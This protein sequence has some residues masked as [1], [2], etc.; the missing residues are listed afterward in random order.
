MI[1]ILGQILF[2]TMAAAFALLVVTLA[3]VGLSTVRD[4]E[5]LYS[6]GERLF[7]GVFGVVLCIFCATGTTILTYLA[8]NFP[9]MV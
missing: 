6:T 2:G 4:K 1:I 8:I 9:D 7:H 5:G 3:I